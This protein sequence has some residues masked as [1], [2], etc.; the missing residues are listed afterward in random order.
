MSK[1]S[2]ISKRRLWSALALFVV[3]GLMSTA[4]EE[5]AAE[6]SLVY[7]GTYTSGASAGIYVFRFNSETGSTTGAMLAAE[8]DNPSF[9]AIHPNGEWLYAV[10]E[11]GVFEGESAGALSSFGINRDGLGLKVGFGQP[12][13][14][15]GQEQA[16]AL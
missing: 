10:N 11:L 15:A 12:L 6:E 14:L 8:T 7:V 2:M 3:G 5:A 16:E 1:C 4:S 13:P 9:V